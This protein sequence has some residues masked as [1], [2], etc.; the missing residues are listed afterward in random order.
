MACMSGTSG[1]LRTRREA[2]AAAAR[3]LAVVGLV[4]GTS[5][6]VSARFGDRVLV[7]PTGA[8]LAEL[9]ASEVCV[10]D[11][12]GRVLD[13]PFAPTSELALHLGVY[14][15]F[16]AG[17]VVHTHAPMA[18]A[19]GCVLD[20]LPCIHYEMLALGGSVRVAPYRT[21][22][23]QELADAALDALRDRKAVLLAN[24]GAI[25]HA[26]DLAGAVRA[27]EL[28]EWATTLYWRARQLGPARTLSAQE[29]QDVAAAMASRG[30]GDTQPLPRRSA[31]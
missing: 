11:R 17:A 7:T 25:T 26:D 29:L 9:E 27:T 15:R 19:V 21:F 6:N 13:G 14:D 20:E 2:V 8:V 5:G 30:Y 28:L 31:A 12:A 10:L 24:H 4:T 3:R 16:R 22:G 18:T 23:T 1:T